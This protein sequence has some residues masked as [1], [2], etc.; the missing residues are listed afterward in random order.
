MREYLDRHRATTSSP[1]LT[2]HFRTYPLERTAP[3][4]PTP[5]RPSSKGKERAPTPEEVQEVEEVEE[6]EA[7]VDELEEV[8]EPEEEKRASRKAKKEVKFAVEPKDAAT[9]ADAY[10][11]PSP[12][13][14]IL[15]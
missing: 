10:V 9:V 7:E 13:P 12:L 8:P 4:P 6:D 11:L 1:P 3:A 14:F 2:N 5:T 15:C